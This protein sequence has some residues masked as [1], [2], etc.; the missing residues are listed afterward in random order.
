MIAKSYLVV[1]SFIIALCFVGCSSSSNL[2]TQPDSP[3]LPDAELSSSNTE[4]LLTGTLEIDTESMTITQIDDRQSDTVYVIPSSILGSCPGGCFNFRIVSIVGTVL[5]IELELE[6]PTAIQA[7]DLRLVCTRLIG[8]EVVNP[9]SYTDF[10]GTPIWDVNPFIALGKE[11]PN[12]AFPIG[13]GGIDTE[14]LYLNYDGGFCSIEYAITASLPGNVGEPYEISGMNQNGELTPSGG[15]AIIGCRVDD[16]QGNVSG[17]YLDAIPFT[18]NPVELLSVGGGLFEV[19]I[20]NTAGAPLGNYNQLIMALSP[21]PQNIS[22]YNYVEITVSEDVIVIYVDNSNTTG[23]E[24]GTQEHPFDTIQEALAVAGAGYEIRVDDS[25][26]DY[27]G[28]VLLRYEIPLKSVNWDTSDGGDMAAIHYGGAD[29][30]VTAVANSTIDGF[31][32]YGSSTSGVYIDGDNAIVRNCLITDIGETFISSTVEGIRVQHGN[33]VQIENCEITNLQ[34]NNPTGSGSINCIYVNHGNDITITGCDIHAIDITADSCGV[35]GIYF[36]TCNGVDFNNNRIFDIQN[37]VSDITAVY[38]NTCDNVDF[39]HNEIYALQTNDGYLMAVYFNHCDVVSFSNNIIYFISHIGIFSG[40]G[41]SGLYFNTTTNVDFSNN[42]IDKLIAIQ[43]SISR[44]IKVDSNST[45]FIGINN[46]VGMI[47]SG[48]GV[49]LSAP[50]ALWEYNDV[51]DCAG[52]IPPGTGNISEDPEFVD[53]YDYHLLPGSPCIDTGDPTIFDVD[54][55]RSDMGC[56]GGPF[57][58]W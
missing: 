16:Y 30:I 41:L 11:Y 40:G 6:N 1:L 53:S 35:F 14:T 49:V 46:I 33:N 48:D 39:I 42:V 10:P 5:E 28:P 4:V 9:D 44:G 36:N 17:V 45:N 57:G 21:N 13:P 12:R 55:S 52:G 8:F 24:D 37:T 23:I 29:D 18:G 51:Y 22:T 56:Y 19:E 15:S 2:P 3:G 50:D 43:S 54:T 25:G 58:D 20:S 38:I 31:K 7:Y 32:L 27:M 47:L 34:M 26:M